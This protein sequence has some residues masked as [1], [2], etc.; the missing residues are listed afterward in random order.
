MKRIIRYTIA[1]ALV[2]AMVSCGSDL[3]SE[4]PEVPS[5]L[6]TV[7]GTV[8]MEILYPAEAGFENI[9][10]AKADIYEDADTVLDALKAYAAEN[11]LAV[12]V[13]N[14]IYTYV[15]G[16]GGIS[17]KDFGNNTGWVFTVNNE[18]VME[19]ADTCTLSDGDMVSWQ[20]VDYSDTSI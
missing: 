7:I 19:G 9:I 11:D 1:L 16:I 8:S 2:I 12:V 10:D 6:E 5:S 17:E 3:D 15:T 14:G 20:Y 4:D 13:E 18:M